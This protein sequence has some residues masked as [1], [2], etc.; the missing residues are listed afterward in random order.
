MEIKKDIKKRQYSLS[1]QPIWTVIHLTEGEASVLADI[2]HQLFDDDEHT[3]AFG[4][5]SESGER[6]RIAAILEKLESQCDWV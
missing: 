4:L 6:V 1:P 3:G 2:L 5:K